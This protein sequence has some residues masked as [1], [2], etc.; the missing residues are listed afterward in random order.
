MV[1]VRSLEWYE[2][3]MNLNCKDNDVLRPDKGGL[4]GCIICLKDLA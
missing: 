2:N 3:P 4:A 1:G